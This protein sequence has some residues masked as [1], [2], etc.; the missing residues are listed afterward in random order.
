MS[1]NNPAVYPSEHEGR[2][3]STINEG[4]SLRDHFAGLVLSAMVRNGDTGGPIMLAEVA[5]RQADQM[6]KIREK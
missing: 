2:G 4:L 3:F 6:L 1:Y 5:Y